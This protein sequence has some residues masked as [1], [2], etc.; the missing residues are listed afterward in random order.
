M[1]SDLVVQV[2]AKA[3]P[4]PPS[5][6]PF[7]FRA[8]RPQMAHWTL[9]FQSLVSSVQIYMRSDPSALR[10]LFPPRAHRTFSTSLVVS[11]KPKGP[12]TAPGFDSER[13]LHTFCYEGHLAS[14][15]PFCLLST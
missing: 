12:L 3:S 11:F 13:Q 14:R 9:A 8:F 2:E 7:P 15:F 10:G 5:P 1:S 6:K 4:T